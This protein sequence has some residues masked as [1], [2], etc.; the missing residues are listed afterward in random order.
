MFSQGRQYK[1]PPSF[2]F[3]LH[4]TLFCLRFGVFNLSHETAKSEKNVAEV[5]KKNIK[6][7][8]QNLSIFGSL[9]LANNGNQVKYSYGTL[10][11]VPF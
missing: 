2:C 11:P 8:D 7:P 4:K 1:I 5:R 9:L 10:D 3:P 6:Q